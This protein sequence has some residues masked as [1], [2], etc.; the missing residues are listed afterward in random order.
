M[1]HHNANARRIANQLL[2]A[3]NTNM[4][5]II[6]PNQVL[7]DDDD[8]DD[9]D[10]AELQF[11]APA[12]SIDAEATLAELTDDES[13]EADADAE[14]DAEA[15]ATGK[16]KASTAKAD[17]R[18]G[19]KKPRLEP[20]K[21]TNIAKAAD[22]PIF[23]NEL[24]MP[25]NIAKI[26]ENSTALFPYGAANF[27]ILPEEKREQIRQE[28][29]AHSH[30]MR[31][32]APD[33]FKEYD[34][35]KWSLTIDGTEYTIEMKQQLSNNN[36]Q[37]LVPCYNNPKPVAL[38]HELYVPYLRE[39]ASAFGKKTVKLWTTKATTTKV[40]ATKKSLW[41]MYAADKTRELFD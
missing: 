9:D 34:G 8:D 15:D 17:V 12:E 13:A 32:G 35:L 25:T 38:D 30:E 24:R 41:R 36:W 3:K 29:L 31:N 1:L 23:V 28:L 21:P 6:E 18:P 20:K 5:R 4:I 2:F 16:R 26:N 10:G 40:T 11:A 14:A 27:V 7:N 22:E 37:M 19:V 39:P 33:H